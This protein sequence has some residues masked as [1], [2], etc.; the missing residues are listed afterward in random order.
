MMVHASYT[1]FTLSSFECT[2]GYP[3]L[4]W[5]G[6]YRDRSSSIPIAI[7]AVVHLEVARVYRRR[8]SALVDDWSKREVT[9]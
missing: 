3:W 2:L 1:N 6:D 7:G 5:K 4:L 9:L 8:R